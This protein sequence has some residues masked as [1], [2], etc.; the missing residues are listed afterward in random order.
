[1]GKGAQDLVPEYLS[2]G[3]DLAFKAWDQYEAKDYY[4]AKDSGLAALDTYNAITIGIE[5]YEFRNEAIALDKF[6]FASEYIART[7]N[8][9]VDALNQYE[10]TGDVSAAL[11]S[12][13]KFRD[14]YNAIVVALEAFDIREMAIAKGIED[15]VPEGPEYLERT[16]NIALQ[17][18]AL[19]DYNG[20]ANAVLK[21]SLALK[22]AYSTMVVALDTYHTREKVIAL[23]IEDLV[24]EGPA[25]LNGTDAYA[26]LALDYYD[27][28]NYSDAYDLAVRL[29]EAYGVMVTG[30][31][32][33]YVR[34]E[35]VDGNFYQYD[36]DALEITDIYALSALADYENANIEL[37]GF[38][39][40]VAYDRY[41]QSLTRTKGAYVAD[42][43]SSANGARLRALE[44]KA[45]VAA[46]TEYDAANTVFIQGVN[47]FND[48][49]YTLAENNYTQSWR[50]F[51]TSTDVALQKRSLAEAAIQAAD[52][53]I[54]ASDEAAYRAELLIGGGV[55]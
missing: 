1:M 50:M 19:Y 44:N 39:A 27:A 33:Y 11:S 6:G 49:N 5:A 40:H 54:A 55:R 31:Q 3:N 47:A 34:Q 24:P 23:G 17:A 15:I 28:G 18:L 51:N 48:K 53:S 20:D 43:G 12:S 32:A 2:D 30:L 13:I 42:I 25:Y 4:G 7:D 45:N 26:L 37:A 35:M 14:T 41:S 10:S 38:K 16:D 9:A 21:S 52:A 8:A 36:A 46:R 29:E 22:E